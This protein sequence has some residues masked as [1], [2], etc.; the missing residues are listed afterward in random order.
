MSLWVG[1]LLVELHA[2]DGELVDL[3]SVALEEG[4]AED[5]HPA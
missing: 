4:E 1:I 3:V 5:G 2:L